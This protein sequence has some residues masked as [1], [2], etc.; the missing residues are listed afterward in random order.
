MQ[1]LENMKISIYQAN[2]KEDKSNKPYT[3]YMIYCQKNSKNWIVR[4][5]FMDFCNLNKG[6]KDLYRE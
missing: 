1:Q 5:K 3:E 4:R 6:L 2:I